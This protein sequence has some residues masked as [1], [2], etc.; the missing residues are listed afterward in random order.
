M[1]AT[2]I[3]EKTARAELRFF[4]ASPKKVRLV[5][6]E[7]KGKKAEEAIQI[8][9]FIPKRFSRD[10][11]KL[12]SSAM[13]NAENKGLDKERL[14][15]EELVCNEGPRLKR[16]RPGHRGIAFPYTR[17]LCHIRVVLR[18]AE[19]EIKTKKQKHGKKS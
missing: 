2:E 17:K 6:R 7:L 1:A 8:L 18:E 15:I 3:R 10:L 12:I 4:R 5:L 13:S 11:I 9:K 19:A 14:V 16:Y